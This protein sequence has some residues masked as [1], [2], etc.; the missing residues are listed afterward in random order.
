V[1]L[2]PGIS[3]A[4]VPSNVLFPIVQA[5]ECQMMGSDAAQVSFCQNPTAPVPQPPSG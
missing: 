2:P 1:T 4:D 3:S 5:K